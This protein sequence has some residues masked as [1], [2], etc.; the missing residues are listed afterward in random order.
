M[1]MAL[2]LVLA[3][4]AKARFHNAALRHGLKRFSLKL[5]CQEQLQPVPISVRAS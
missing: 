1:S 4:G 5:V 3:S 2:F